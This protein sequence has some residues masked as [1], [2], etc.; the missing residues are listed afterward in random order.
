MRHYDLL[1][2][3]KPSTP[4]LLSK[5]ILISRFKESGTKRA[6]DFKAGVNNGAGDGFRRLGIS[7]QS[8]FSPATMRSRSERSRW[9]DRA[10]APAAAKKSCTAGA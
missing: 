10:T 4:K 8:G 2:N 6:M 7:V 5:T 3:L 9:M 1:Q